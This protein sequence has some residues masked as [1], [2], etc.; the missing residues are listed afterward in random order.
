MT[1]RT[2]AGLTMLSA[3][4]AVGCA[5]HTIRHGDGQAE[6]YLRCP[7]ARE[8][9]L[10]TSLDGFVPHQARRNALGQWVVAVNTSRDFSYFYLV[11]GK[12]LTPDCRMVEQDEFGGINCVYSDNP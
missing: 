7:Q 6:F 5:S 12:V 11:D 1:I 9:A 3:L 10:V 4:L 2:F 8:V